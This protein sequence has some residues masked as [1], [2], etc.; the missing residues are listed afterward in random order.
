MPI[1]L[2]HSADHYESIE[3]VDKDA[4]QASIDLAIQVING[5]YHF[6]R[7]DMKEFLPPIFSSPDPI[8]GNFMN[9]PKRNSNKEPSIANTVAFDFNKTIPPP[10]LV[11]SESTKIERIQNEIK[12]LLLIPKKERSSKEKK[13]LEKNL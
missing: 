4:E 10:P 7:L 11:E 3:P 9:E 12:S 13:D 5:N 6:T 2:A 8:S 1:I